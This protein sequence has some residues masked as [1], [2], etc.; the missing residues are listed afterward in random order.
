MSAKINQLA[1]ERMS[2]LCHVLRNS[3]PVAQIGHSI[4]I[5]HL[6]EEEARL[7]DFARIDRQTEPKEDAP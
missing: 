3:E 1:P 7:I 2:R 6:T 5:Y 4:L